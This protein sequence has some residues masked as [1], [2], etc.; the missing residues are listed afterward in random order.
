MFNDPTTTDR[1]LH[2]D[3]HDGSSIGTGKFTHDHDD[4][5]S[6]RHTG[7]SSESVTELVNDSSDE[8]FKKMGSKV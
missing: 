3:G 6:Q 8:D 5:R 4:D 2:A 7:A 1:G